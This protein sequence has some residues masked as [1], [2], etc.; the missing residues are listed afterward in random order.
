MRR[1]LHT[2]LLLL[3]GLGLLA[4]CHHDRDD[5]HEGQ[6]KIALHPPTGPGKRPQGVGALT[7][8]PGPQPFTKADVVTYFQSHNLPKNSASLSQLHVDS[9]EF[10]T[11]KEVSVRLQGASTGLAD[12]D[13]IG[14]VTLTGTFIFTGP[15]KDK[16][17]IFNRAYAAFDAASGNLLMV[18]TLESANQPK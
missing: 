2:S 13:R 14:F 4:G 1:T 12:A 5:E 16:P 11:S 18:G 17:A 10:I 15:G 9:L 6:K 3:A 7:V 8:K